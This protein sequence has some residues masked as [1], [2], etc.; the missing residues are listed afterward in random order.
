MSG[1]WYREAKGECVCKPG[2]EGDVAGQA[3]T[4]ELLE[5]LPVYD[6]N[7]IVA[8]YHHV[9][10]KRFTFSVTTLAILPG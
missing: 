6:L 9:S 7:I 5:L 3:C 2:Y 8:H 1:E 10:S 4:G